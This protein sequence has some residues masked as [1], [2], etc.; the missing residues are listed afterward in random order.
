M[1]IGQP[2]EFVQTQPG[3]AYDLDG[4]RRLLGSNF[5]V[6]ARSSKSRS[7]SGLSRCGTIS[8]TSAY[9]SPGRPLG[10]GRPRPFSRN[11]RPVEVPFGTFTVAS[12]P[13]VLM[14]TEAPSAPSQTAS[15]RS[16][17]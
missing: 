17:V 7:S 6:P 8:F 13:G 1:E 5:D 10:L 3:P 16:T 11:L 12:P 9:K 2:A 14:S 4:H 15:G